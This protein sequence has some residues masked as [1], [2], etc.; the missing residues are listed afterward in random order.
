MPDL[1]LLGYIPINMDEFIDFVVNGKKDANGK[2]LKDEDDR[3]ITGVMAWLHGREIPM[4][5]FFSSAP[6]D[7]V[8]LF[9]SVI[10]PTE[11]EVVPWI[12]R[13]PGF[14]TMVRE[15]GKMGDAPV[16]DVGVKSAVI[17]NPLDFVKPRPDLD[18]IFIDQQATIAK[19]DFEKVDFSKDDLLRTLQGRRGRNLQALLGETKKTLN[20]DVLG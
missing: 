2:P 20:L 1:E 6:E 17:N 18:Q 10:Q 15:D 19:I 12:S 5:R 4:A 16:P 14:R 13:I 9:V 11:D 7:P 8:Q 3:E